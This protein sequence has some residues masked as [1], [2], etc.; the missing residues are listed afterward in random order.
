MLHVSKFCNN[1]ICIA[2]QPSVSFQ[3]GHMSKSRM[4]VLSHFGYI[5]GLDFLVFSMCE[6]CLCGKQAH[7]IV[8]KKRSEPL[9]LIHSEVCNPMPIVSMGEASYFL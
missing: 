1:V 6:H 5:L 8:N 2:K 7:S 9:E 3:L 4:Q